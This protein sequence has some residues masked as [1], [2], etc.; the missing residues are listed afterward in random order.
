MAVAAVVVEVAVVVDTDR[1]GRGTSA[2]GSSGTD[3][4]GARLACFAARLLSDSKCE[5][6]IALDL[7]GLS[8]VTDY[9]VI[10]T[11]TSER[12][13]RSIADDVRKLA[14]IQ[15]RGVILPEGME[16]ASWIVV[17]CFDVVVHLFAAEARAYYDLE[18]LW[19][20]A[21]STL[22]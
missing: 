16:S 7:R 12:Q 20:D 3:S 19:A 18:S 6:V 21:P 8:Q 15:D 5:D 4:D 22:R 2:S 10:A 9:Y 11:G 14:R 13:L 17:D 1:G